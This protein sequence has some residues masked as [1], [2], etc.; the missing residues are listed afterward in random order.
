MNTDILSINENSLDRAAAII[1]RGG[2]VAFPTETV[3]G[4]G[5]DALKSEAVKLIY[6]VKGRPSDNPLIAHVHKDY[7][8]SQLVENIP[9]YAKLLAKAFCRGRL[10][11]CITAGGW[12]AP[13]FRAV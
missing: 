9:E 13:K 4:L 3:Y 10:P 6:A 7:D 1:E 12:S 8:I 5:A 2:L 11:W